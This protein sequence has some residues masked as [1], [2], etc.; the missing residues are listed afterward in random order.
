MTPRSAS[1]V[2]AVYVLA[3]GACTNAGDD[4]GSQPTTAATFGAAPTAPPEPVPV[5]TID[6]MTITEPVE[7]GDGSVSSGVAE[8]P[9]DTSDVARGSI[10]EGAGQEL[11]PLGSTVLDVDTGAGR[12]QLGDADVPTMAAS[13]PVPD[14]LDVQLSSETANDAGFSGVIEGTVVEFADFY[15]LGLPAAGFEVL[16]EQ[17]V[18]E[19]ADPLDLRAVVLVFESAE[20][21][22]SVAIALAPGEEMVSI[23]VTI[24]NR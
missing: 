19:G 2:V 9:L 14:G 10:P 23:L 13:F 18:P 20:Q 3:L 6:T 17:R 16:S 22:G 24:A 12:V 11:G 5:T 7:D 1:A 4:S 15:V 8:P 21:E